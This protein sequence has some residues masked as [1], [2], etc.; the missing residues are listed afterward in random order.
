MRAILFENVVV[1]LSK[2]LNI[3]RLV[4]EQGNLMKPFFPTLTNLTLKCEHQFSQSV[5]F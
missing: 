1:V 4:S 3:Y 5:N 2:E